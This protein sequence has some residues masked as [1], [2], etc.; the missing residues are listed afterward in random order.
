MFKVKTSKKLFF[1]V[2]FVLEFVNDNNKLEIEEDYLLM[3]KEI[4]DKVFEETNQM[5]VPVINV[6]YRI[7]DYRIINKYFEENY[8]DM[9]PRKKDCLENVLTVSG[10][11]LYNNDDDSEKW[12]AAVILFCERLYSSFKDECDNFSIKIRQ[13]GFA[14]NFRYMDTHYS[15][16]EN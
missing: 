8:Q 15:I 12:K 1:H 4:A 10:S 16:W 7:E 13:K 6:G 14:V 2:D 5:I 3:V 9:D 11:S